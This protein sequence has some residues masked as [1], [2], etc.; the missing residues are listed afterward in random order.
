MPEEGAESSVDRSDEPAAHP[1][2]APEDTVAGSLLADERLVDRRILHPSSIREAI[3]SGRGQVLH[4]SIPR[5]RTP[6]GL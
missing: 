2:K 1:R 4:S 5:R 6:H 3:R